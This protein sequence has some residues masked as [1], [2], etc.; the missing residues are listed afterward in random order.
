[1][2]LSSP[3][4]N[5]IDTIR[6]ATDASLPLR[7]ENRWIDGPHSRSSIHGISHALPFLVDSGEPPA[8]S[9]QDEAPSPSEHLLH[10]LASSLTESVVVLAAQW[11]LDLYAVQTTVTAVGGFEA[12][13]RIE[14]AVEVDGDAPPDRLSALVA[15]AKARSVVLGIVSR[16]VTVEVV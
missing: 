10:A 14:F 15:M 8:L 16:G 6:L 11:D 5:G 1:M 3:I 12:L 7:V 4:R 2:T 13:E 9:G